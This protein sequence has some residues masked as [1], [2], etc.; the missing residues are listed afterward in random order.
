MVLKGETEGQDRIAFVTYYKGEYEIHTI[1]LK[2]PL[3]T[4][5]SSDFGAPGP[6]IDFEPPVTVTF[7]PANDRK[8]G[9]FEK[10][11]LA[12]RPP[13]SIGVTSNG[14]VYGGTQLDDQRRAR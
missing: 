5:A 8:K 4:V 2:E 10:M 1:Q 14:D 11:F 7:V 13:V 6:I 12:G 3:H 9:R